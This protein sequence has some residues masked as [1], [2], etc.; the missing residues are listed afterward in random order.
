MYIK[1][2]VELE[3]IN[4]ELKLKMHNKYV[5]CGEWDLEFKFPQS[6]NRYVTTKLWVNI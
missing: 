6:Q 3:N 5:L 1:S 4:K 2:E